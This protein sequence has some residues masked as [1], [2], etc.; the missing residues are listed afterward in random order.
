M[1]GSLMDDDILSAVLGRV[2]PAHVLSAAIAQDFKRVRIAGVSYPALVPATGSRADGLL[3]DRLAERDV[4]RLAAYEGASYEIAS[5]KAIRDD[6]SEVEAKY[7]RW[8]GQRALV[9]EPW[10]FDAWK[11][12]AKAGMLGAARAA[13]RAG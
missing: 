8:I 9:D 7:W 10:D 3:V 5:L 1:F 13:G 11:R 4:A 12:T 6:G 2:V